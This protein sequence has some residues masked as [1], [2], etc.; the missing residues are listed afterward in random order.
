MAERL[1]IEAAIARNGRAAERRYIETDQ[2]EE[3]Q[4]DGTTLT[5]ER[6]KQPASMDRDAPEAPAQDKGTGG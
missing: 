2:I 5:I 6:R 4:T 1:W 3:R